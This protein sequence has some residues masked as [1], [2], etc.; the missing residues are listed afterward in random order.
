MSEYEILRA[1]I[2]HTPAS[3]FTTEPALQSFEDGGLLVRDGRVVSCGDYQSVVAGCPSA[4]TRDWRGGFILPG[5]VDTHLH[6]PQLR[7][8]GGLG[9][10]L[11]DW[12]DQVALPEEVRMADVAYAAE[13][14]R[15]FVRAL[16]AHGTTTA[17]VFGA[18]FTSATRALF[19]A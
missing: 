3:P 19:E 4:S 14:A 15:G 17:L 6:F 18:H 1:S 2:L 10:T 7:I 9:R 12:L 11:L 16:A 5:M 13:I 8:M